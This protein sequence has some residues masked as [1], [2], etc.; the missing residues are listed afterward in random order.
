MIP[1]PPITFESIT[2]PPLRPITAHAEQAHVPLII[3]RSSACPLVLADSDGVVSRQHARLTCHPGEPSPWRLTDL[4]SRHGTFVNGQ[5]LSPDVPTPLSPGDQ[6]RIGPWTLRVIIGEV[7]ATRRRAMTSDDRRFTSTMMQR[8]GD[9]SLDAGAQHR[10]NILMR[11]A[12]DLPGAQTEEDVASI[13]LR[14][15]VE[16]AG[17]PRCAILRCAGEEVEVLAGHDVGDARFSRSL[18]QAAADPANDGQTVI[19]NPGQSPSGSGHSVTLLEI[20]AALCA[21]V[22]VE[23]LPPARADDLYSSTRLPRGVPVPEAFLYLD[24]RG[25]S[26]G[27]ILITS[28]TV[29]FC[30]AVARVCGLALTNLSRRRVEHE[31]NRRHAELTAARDVQRIIMPPPRGAFGGSGGRLRLRYH[32]ESIPGRF[33]A[34]DLFDIF[35][36]GDD[37][38]CLVLG[39]VVGKGAAAGMVMAN[40]QAHLAHL[41]RADPDPAVA[42]TKASALVAR[43]SDRLGE[44]HGRVSL[45]ISAFACSIDLRSGD[46]R[47]ADA[48]HGYAIL[49]P[50]GSQPSCPFVAGGTPLGVTDDA[51]YHSDVVHAGAGARLVVFSDGLAEQRTKTGRAFGVDGALASVALAGNDDPARILV[52]TLR[53]DCGNT[54]ADDV[55]VACVLFE[56]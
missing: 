14:A 12:A 25:E 22:L 24:A 38:V 52:D 20:S 55:T 13:T 40:I 43:Y 54:F 41:L 8:L 6:V 16:G 42:L 49:H 30:Q 48:G 37:R 17:F 10:L 2:G 27:A 4:H 39:D 51:E 44:E 46:I 31:S 18:I 45:F 19:L 36:V 32:V 34:G 7:A 28:E 35:G 33:V 26:G 21:P 1:T 29:A 3:G 15:L 50:A 47:Y 9:Q 23:R 5:R 11:C 56:R 53:N